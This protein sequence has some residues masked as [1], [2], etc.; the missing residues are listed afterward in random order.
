VL[1][2]DEP[3]AALDSGSEQQVVA[4]LEER[5]KGKTVIFV[6]HRGALLQLADRIIVMDSGKVVADGPRDELLKAMNKQ[7]A[8]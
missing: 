1:L 3:T 7:S 6:T 2:L 8:E 4:A 5:T